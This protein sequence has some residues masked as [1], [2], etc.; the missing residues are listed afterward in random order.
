[1]L[2]SSFSAKQYM[3]QKLIVAVL[4]ATASAQELQ[5]AGAFER[6]PLA[7]LRSSPP[8]CP[9]RNTQTAQHCGDDVDATCPSIQ[10]EKLL[11]QSAKTAAHL[12]GHISP[13]HTVL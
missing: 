9:A 1:M 6:N 12:R 8:K 2:S 7:P 3:V 10:S 5:N 13:I 11:A 4:L